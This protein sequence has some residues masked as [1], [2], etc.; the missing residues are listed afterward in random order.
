MRTHFK[1]GRPIGQAQ[2]KPVDMFSADPAAPDIVILVRIRM[3]CA[4]LLP[5]QVNPESVNMKL[6][7]LSGYLRAIEPWPDVVEERAHR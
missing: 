5:Q 1:I 7:Q 6:H 2:Q 4:E 3:S